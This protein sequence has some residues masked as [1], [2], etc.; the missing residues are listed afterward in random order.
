MRNHN[1]AIDASADS[2]K[3]AIHAYDFIAG[4]PSDEA[5]QKCKI[6][7]KTSK[8]YIEKHGSLRKLNSAVGLAYI[9]S[10]NIKTDDGL[11]NGAPC[12]LKKI[13]FIPSI[14]WV[15][16]DDKMIGRQWRVRY[17]N[18]HTED[19]NQNWTPIFAVDRHFK[20]RNARVIR[21]PFPLKPAAGS[22]IHSGQGC[23][24]DR[25]FV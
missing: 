7:V 2:E 6:L 24:F 8:K 5:K 14:L 20:T 13:Q 23:T 4:N 25:K 19:T 10:I 3:M 15:L 16:F 17:W 22:T 11:I 1:E 12:T 18:L 9:T 21:T